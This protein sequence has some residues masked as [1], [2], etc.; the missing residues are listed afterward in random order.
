MD[1]KK[2]TTA[3]HPSYK[4]KKW[5]LF[6]K[7]LYQE[8]SFKRW[9]EGNNITTE[10]GTTILMQKL[11]SYTVC[12]EGHWNQPRLHIHLYLFQINVMCIIY[13]LES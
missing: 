10:I 11:F 3:L 1:K 13:T 12:N 7:K 9:E 8:K 5:N 2:S 6:D 4:E